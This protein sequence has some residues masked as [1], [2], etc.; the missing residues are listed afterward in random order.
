MSRGYDGNSVRRKKFWSILIIRRGKLSE[1]KQ[2]LWTTAVKSFCAVFVCLL[3]TWRGAEKIY[4]AE[5]I[6]PSS[7]I[8]LAVFL[9]LLAI[10]GISVVATFCSRDKLYF[11]FVQHPAKWKYVLTGCCCF[12]LWCG[13]LLFWL[14]IFSFSVHLYLS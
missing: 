3:P 1:D 4:Q 5:N 12:L 14:V 9:I 10:F 13:T 6:L 8:G 2:H 11:L 7:E